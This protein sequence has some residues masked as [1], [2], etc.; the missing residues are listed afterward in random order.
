MRDPQLAGR[1]QRAA[2]RLESAWERWRV[3]HGLAV[4]PAQP[5]VSY[6]GYSLTE[7]WG[8]PRVVIG[9][10]A[11][12]AEFLADF[13]DR[14]HRARHGHVAVQ[15][16]AQL[17]RPQE[18]QVPPQPDPLR[19]GPLQQVT[20][21]EAEDAAGER[22]GPPLLRAPVAP[23]RGARSPDLARDMTAELAGW[24]SGELPGQ[25]TERLAGWQPGA[26]AAADQPPAT[27]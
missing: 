14:E 4:S 2:T 25:A 16:A 24:T 3:L 22:V 20:L 18:A 7:P 1:A 21:A 27:A 13:L 6:V 23:G 12:E 11:D 19:S 10:D 15:P 9:I 17:P 8:Q 5:V 26:P